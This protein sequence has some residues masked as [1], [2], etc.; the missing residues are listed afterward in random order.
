MSDKR[1][2]PVMGYSHHSCGYENVIVRYPK[3]AIEKGAARRRE[4]WIKKVR[5]SPELQREYDPETGNHR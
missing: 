5:C 1:K 2:P 3:K 4:E